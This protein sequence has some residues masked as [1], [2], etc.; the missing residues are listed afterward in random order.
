MWTSNT[1]VPPNHHRDGC[2]LAIYGARIAIIVGGVEHPST[3]LSPPPIVRGSFD[4][5]ESIDAYLSLDDDGSLVVYRSRKQGDNERIEEC[6]YAIGLAGCNSAGRRFVN[7]SN[8]ILR[9]VENLVS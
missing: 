3:F 7:I 8:T 5:E 9:S 2:A 6:V 4:G 1:Y